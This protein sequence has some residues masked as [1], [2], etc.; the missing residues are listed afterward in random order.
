MRAAATRETNKTFVERNKTQ[1]DPKRRKDET[2]QAIVIVKSHLAGRFT[3]F[4]KPL[5]TTSE[6]LAAFYVRLWKRFGV[7]TDS[8]VCCFSSYII[9][10]SNSPQDCDSKRIFAVKVYQP[11]L[12][13]VGRGNVGWYHFVF[14]AALLLQSLLML[15]SMGEPY[16]Q[17]LAKAD[18]EGFQGM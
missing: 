6:Q 7:S 1:A 15:S 4:H 10:V 8:S 9:M 14:G 5:A 12:A 11:K 13:L 18:R 3:G 16:H 2:R 17:F